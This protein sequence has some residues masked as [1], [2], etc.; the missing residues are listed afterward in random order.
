MRLS[1]SPVSSSAEP[2]PDTVSSYNEKVPVIVTTEKKKKK[3]NLQVGRPEPREE[4]TFGSS[5]AGWDHPPKRCLVL[6]GETRVGRGW[7]GAH[8]G[9]RARGC[10]GQGAGEL[11]Q[12]SFVEGSCR[13][14]SQLG[15][16]PLLVP[17]HL[18]LRQGPHI[19]VPRRPTSRGARP[20]GSGAA[21]GGGEQRAGSWLPG[22]RGPAQVKVSAAA[23]T[24][25]WAEWEGEGAEQ[26]GAC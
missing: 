17:R 12:S 23:R 6:Q 8:L 26:E 5:F 20:P 10:T 1:C 3:V 25:A 15:A 7:P 21:F 22:P 19:S 11:P 14:G 24:P 18:A 13:F 16:S 9:V 2:F 4:L